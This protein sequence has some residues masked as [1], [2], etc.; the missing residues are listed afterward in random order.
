ML[1]IEIDDD[2]YG[3]LEKS[4]QG[5]NETPNA[6]LRRLL[7]V[8]STPNSTSAVSPK[9]AL[10]EYMDGGSFA[11]WGGN[12]KKR[13][14]GLLSFLHAT[15]PKRFA[16][17]DGYRRGSRIH[18]SKSR[19]AIETSGQSTHPEPI[20]KTEYYAITNLPNALKRTILEE[21]LRAYGFPAVDI[22]AACKALSDRS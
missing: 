18:L 8:G 9:S 3:M 13:Y 6:V 2:V 19:E 4:V 15:D 22:E 10:R 17:F 21:L 5:F 11:F 20:P 12:A 1:T 16:E 14:L 7:A